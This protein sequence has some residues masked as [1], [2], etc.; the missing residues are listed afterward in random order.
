MFDSSFKILF[1]FLGI[2]VVIYIIGI[3]SRHRFKQKLA[4]YCR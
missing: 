3:V 2:C 1:F 4:G